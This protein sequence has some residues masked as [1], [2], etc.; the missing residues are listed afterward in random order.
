[1]LRTH[2]NAPPLS[3]FG[4]VRSPDYDKV[5]FNLLVL[6]AF[7][8]L[9]E[10]LEQLRTEGVFTSQRR[11][12][13]ELMKNSLGVMAWKDFAAVDAARGQRNRIAHEQQLLDVSQC[14]AILDLIE[15]E[16][17]EWRVLPTPIRGTYSVGIT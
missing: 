2:A 16:L 14:E 6:N 8:G 15:A 3:P 4:F 9:E 10:V 5:A 13:A 1:M 7:A 12:L 17:L 11:K